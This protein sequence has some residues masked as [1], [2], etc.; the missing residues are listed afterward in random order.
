MTVLIILTLQDHFKLIA[1]KAEHRTVAEVTADNFAGRNQQLV[2]RFMSMGVIRHLQ[3]VYVEGDHGKFPY[4]PFFYPRVQLCF[5]V[6]TGPL[7]LYAGQRVLI[8]KLFGGADFRFL[9]LLNL[10]QFFQF[11]QILLFSSSTTNL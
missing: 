10:H 8:R 7:V 4:Q 5:I 3:S 9:L 2:S 6:F 11:P 1:A